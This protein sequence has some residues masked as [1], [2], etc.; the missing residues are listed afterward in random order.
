M[1]KPASAAGRGFLRQG[2]A[3]VKN[4]KN[5]PFMEGG[6]DYARARPTY[7]PDLARA[8]ADLCGGRAHAVDV[9][10]GTGQLSAALATVFDTVTAFDPSAS[11][12]ASA[13]E[14]PRIRYRVG[15]AE[16][17]SLPDGSAD[18]VVAAQAAHWFDL[19]RF[20]AEARRI[21]RP[22]GALA[23][24]AYGVPSLEG[25]AGARFE[26]F[27]WRDVHRFWPEARR[28]VEAG[29]RTLPF[30]FAEAAPA[31][32]QIIR[33]W[34]FDAL[35][36]YIGTWSAMRAAREAG[37]GDSMEA[38]LSEIAA[39]WGGETTRHRIAWPILMRAA[40]L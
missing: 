25:P 12:I 24:V 21:L 28:H 27:Y 29:Y 33:E 26:R 11:Q 22:R 5:N 14:H 34:D 32:L 1:N 15:A 36:A 19:K 20:Y 13:T 31:D 16:E 30:P 17:M 37:A 7:P 39:A 2:S 40:I 4:H 35:R 3:R 38:A 8:L 6:E 9:G 10:C 18:L 23:L